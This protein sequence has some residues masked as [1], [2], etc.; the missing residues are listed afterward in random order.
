MFM[1]NR[2][3]AALFFAGV[4]GSALIEPGP[5]RSL[6][7][8]PAG[9]KV[10]K[11]SA[12][13]CQIYTPANVG[14]ALTKSPR[15]LHP[16][17]EQTQKMVATKMIENTSQRLFYVMKTSPAPNEKPHTTY[18]VETATGSGHCIA[19]FTVPPEFP[20]ADAAKIAATLSAA[21]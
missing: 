16:F 12:G 10:S 15:P 17:S 3:W 1:R 7:Q 11:D 9:W 4:L 19:Q 18:Q 21:K 6:P 14:A 5:A 8:V 20:E 13:A 2:T